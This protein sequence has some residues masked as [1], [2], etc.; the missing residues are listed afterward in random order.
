MKMFI[1]LHKF[2]KH[3][4]VVV[5]SLGCKMANKYAVL[6]RVAIDMPIVSSIHDR[7]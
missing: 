6:Y 3:P 4:V 2:D 7:V 1:A 5:L